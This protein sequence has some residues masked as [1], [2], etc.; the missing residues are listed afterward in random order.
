MEQGELLKKEIIKIELIRDVGIADISKYKRLPGRIKLTDYLHDV[1]SVIVYIAKINDMLDKYGNWYVVSLNNFLKQT[2]QKIVTI[3]EKYRLIARGIIDE[4]LNK[5]LIGKVSFRSLAVLAG[6][7]TIG[8]N[9]CLLH[10][11]YGPNVLIGV[12]L[13]NEYF[14]HNLPLNEDICIKCDL[15]I[16]KCP[17]QAIHNDNFNKLKCKDRRKLLGRG[18]G[19]PCITQCPIGQGP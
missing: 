10:P 19:T 17:V 11:I 16:K 7:G 12:V 8:A 3:L 1:K 14:P 9:S 18:C 2:N 15:C 4:H 5:D 13:V 6:L